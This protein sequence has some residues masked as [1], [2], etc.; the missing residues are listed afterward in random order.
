M[1]YCLAAALRH[2][3]ELSF[4]DKVIEFTGHTA[5]TS[6]SS[7]KTI[8]L[9]PGLT[10]AGGDDGNGN[11]GSRSSLLPDGSVSAD[12]KKGMSGRKQQQAMEEFKVRAGCC[13]CCSAALSRHLAYRNLCCC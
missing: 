8:S 1:A 12:K 9:D 7:S 6:S 10:A 3:P 4:I 5:K 13:C 11:N 2:C